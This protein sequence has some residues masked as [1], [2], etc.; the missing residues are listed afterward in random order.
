MGGSLDIV[1]KD[2][3]T[4]WKNIKTLLKKLNYP[5]LLLNASVSDSMAEGKHSDVALSDKNSA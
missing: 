1:M 2:T 5:A 3:S 4:N